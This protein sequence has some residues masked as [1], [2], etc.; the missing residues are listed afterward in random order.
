MSRF[1]DHFMSL[2]DTSGSVK[3]FIKKSERYTKASYLVHD[4]TMKNVLSN[5]DDYG[6]EV[7]ALVKQLGPKNTL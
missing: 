7:K 4:I 6:A 2:H 1:S 3:A 5:F